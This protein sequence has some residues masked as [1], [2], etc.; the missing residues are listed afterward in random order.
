MLK[1][2]KQDLS[3]PVGST[4]Q[5]VYLDCAIPRLNGN[6]EREGSTRTSLRRVVTKRSKGRGAQKG[7]GCKC[8]KKGGGGQGEGGKGK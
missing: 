4:S 7:G 8:K 2:V 6:N 3:T 1:G 5:K